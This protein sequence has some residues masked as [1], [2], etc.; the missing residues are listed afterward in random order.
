M[1]RVPGAIHSWLSQVGNDHRSYGE[2][3]GDRPEAAPAR[4]RKRRLLEMAT[5]SPS[6]A[7]SLS[8][9]K[10][11]IDNGAG[12][13]AG[14]EPNATSQSMASDRS[15]RPTV[16]TLSMRTTLPPS[17]SSLRDLATSTNPPS[18]ASDCQDRSSKGSRRS[19]SPVKNIVGLKRLEKPAYFDSFHDNAAARQLPD[20]VRQLYSDIYNA[21]EYKTGI[22]PAEIRTK[23]EEVNHD[24][25]PPPWV[26]RQPREQDSEEGQEEKRYFDYLP[27]S[28]L[29]STAAQDITVEAAIARA[30]FYKVCHIRDVARECLA[31][32]RS[33]A[34]WN[35]KVHEP[36]LDLAF[37]RQRP[38]LVLF[39]NATAARILPCFLPALGPGE[40]ADGKIVDFTLMPNLSPE[41]DASIQDML[42]QLIQRKRSGTA[43]ADLCV[44]QTEYSPLLR[45]PVAVSIETKVAGASLEEGRLQLAIW[46]AAWHKRIE[47]FGFGGRDGP[48][49]PT[50]PLILTHDHRWELFFAV[51]RIDKIVCPSV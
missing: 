42:S 41:L 28:T 13:G 38:P 49:L 19:S 12:I 43:V 20:D 11:K 36:L 35:S 18:T 31:L 47:K 2:Y 39:E 7:R 26:F 37:S 30:E 24:H 9:K 29:C 16:T 5:L 27:V 1:F 8:P 17:F 10:R 46:I 21:I 4:L 23:I 32:R 45:S 14:I 48:S 3:R 15:N 44:N 33:E 22:Y 6:A 50:L 25:P 51:D 34:A 40:V